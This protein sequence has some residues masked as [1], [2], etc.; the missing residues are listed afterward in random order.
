[1][2]HHPRKLQRRH[3]FTLAEVLMVVSLIALMAVV[4]LPAIGSMQRA[5]NVTKGGALLRDQLLLARQLAIAENASIFVC[6]YEIAGSQGAIGVVLARP[7]ATGIYQPIARP[8]RLPDG[9]VITEDEAWSTLGQLAEAQ[10]RDGATPSD[11]RLL[12][13]KPTGATSLPISQE[14]FLTVCH[15]RAFAKFP[16]QFVTLAIDP[17]TGRVFTYQP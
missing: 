9:I 2:P 16:N 13:F 12:A 6:L 11:C 3:G 7:D 4:A 14:W 5:F 1:M 10:V 15:E 8:R 17:A